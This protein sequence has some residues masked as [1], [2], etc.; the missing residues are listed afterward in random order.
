VVLWNAHQHSVHCGIA[1]ESGNYVGELEKER[2]FISQ[3]IQAVDLAAVGKRPTD[4]D[5][6]VTPATYIYPRHYFA[7]SGD[8]NAMQNFLNYAVNS[9]QLPRD[10]NVGLDTTRWRP[11]C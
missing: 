2:K 6:I 4:S 7:N 1:F 5:D 11:S 8:L 3:A 9:G 10:R